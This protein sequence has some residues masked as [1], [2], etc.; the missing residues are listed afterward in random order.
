MIWMVGWVIGTSCLS[1]SNRI[2]F[3]LTCVERV[4][5]VGFFRDEQDKYLA[6]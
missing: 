4:N 1:R 2:G 6:R 3:D 5:L